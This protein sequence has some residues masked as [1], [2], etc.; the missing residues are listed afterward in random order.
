[1]ITLLA[2]GREEFHEMGHSEQAAALT[3]TSSGNSSPTKD[4]ISDVFPT[5]AV[6]RHTMERMIGAG[7]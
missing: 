5:L 7:T 3:L 2:L 1:M 4:M 6:R